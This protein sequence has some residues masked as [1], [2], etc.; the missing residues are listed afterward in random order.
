MTIQDVGLL[1]LDLPAVPLIASTQ[2]DNATPERVR[3]LQDIGFSR[4]I[5]ARKFA[6]DQI[7][8]IRR[9]TPS[10]AGHSV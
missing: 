1:E 4:V 10:G 7:R 9:E 2:M 6:F 3:F 5:L 8:A